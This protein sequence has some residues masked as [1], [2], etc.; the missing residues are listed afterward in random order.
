MF[1]SFLVRPT[2]IIS[3]VPRGSGMV[4]ENK[5]HTSVFKLR[6]MISN[7]NV[8]PEEHKKTEEQISFSYDKKTLDCIVLYFLSKMKSIGLH[9]LSPMNAKPVK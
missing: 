3:Y 2:N 1:Q 5:L 8:V 6:N 9:C 4:E 7:M